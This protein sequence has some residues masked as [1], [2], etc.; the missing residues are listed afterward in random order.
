MPKENKTKESRDQ[1]ARTI[2][3]IYRPEMEKPFIQKRGFGLGKML[4]ILIMALAAGFAAGVV[5]DNVFDNVYLA[6]GGQ[7]QPSANVGEQEP[8]ILDL[9]FLIQNQ[10][11]AS[12]DKVF[13]E[14]KM[15]IAGFYSRRSSGGILDS[16]LLEKDF[17]GS[18][19]I[20]TSDGWILTHKSVIDGED[21]VIVT[22]DKKILEPVKEVVD[23]F[24][25]TVL[26]KVNAENLSPVRFADIDALTPT[27]PLLATRYSA[28]NHG[29]DI[30]K[31]AIQKFSYHDQSKGA[32]FL[33]TTE[34]IDHYLKVVED[35]DN[36]YN[37]AALLNQDNQVAGL[38]FNSG[39]SFINLAVPAYY[40]KSVTDNFLVN[41]Q[42]IIRGSLGAYYVDLSESVGLPATVTESRFNGAV[43]LGDSVRDILAV[44]KGSVAESAGLKAGDI[45]IRVNNED[46]DERNS[47]TR[48]I[49]D[50][51]PGQTLKLKVIRAGEEMEV[52]VVLGEM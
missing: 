44:A 22:S 27:T 1:R 6:G 52:E 48:L 24:S 9:N 43:L 17:L 32:D 14:I 42:E 7:L 5:Q 28:Q 40:L 21:Y 3:E 39:R 34:K 38:L 23:T 18:G 50:Y 33:L 49:Q 41:S 31:T 37:G 19:V 25:G 30:V 26:V 15:Q 11:N 45:V 46:V 51:T 36:V 47:L 13:S 29:S 4:L 10:N 2:Q 35:F 20:V 16:I 12:Y 8:G